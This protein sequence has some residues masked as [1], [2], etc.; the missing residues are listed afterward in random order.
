MYL[1]KAAKANQSSYQNPA[2]DSFLEMM[3]KITA[4]DARIIRK[5][6][7]ATGIVAAIV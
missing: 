2:P 4:V 3:R 6:S 1:T 7:T 5:T